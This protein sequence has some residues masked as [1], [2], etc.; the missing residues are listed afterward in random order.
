MH[1]GP[2]G[3]Q[4]HPTPG[5]MRGP[6]PPPSHNPAPRLAGRQHHAR[7]ISEPPSIA[8]VLGAVLSVTRALGDMPSLGQLTFGL[9]VGLVEGG[10]EGVGGGE[11][12][13][14]VGGASAGTWGREAR[15]CG[16]WLP[17]SGV[18]R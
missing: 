8:V 5:A 12:A 9:Q 10:G 2:D 1:V 14:G 11:G 17:L 4:E 7:P 16:L 13:G 18:G 3:C 15:C 6:P